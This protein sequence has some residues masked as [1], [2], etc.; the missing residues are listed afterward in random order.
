MK[1]LNNIDLSQNQLLNVR[2]QNL[3]SDPGSPVAGQVWFNTGGNVVKWYNGTVVIDPLARG[4]HTGTQAWTT[5][6]GT[7]T[8]IAGY[9]ILDGGTVTNVSITTANG[10]SGTVATSTTTPAITLTLGAITPTSVTASGTV[11][12]SNFTG[13]STGT[14][15]GDQTTITGNAGTATT[16]ATPRNINGVSFNGSADITVTAAAGTLTG[17]TLAAGVVNSSLT[18][19][20]TLSSL[21]VTG[22]ITAA[23]PTTNTQVATKQY[24]DTLINGL[25][26]KNPVLV[27]TTANITLSGTQ[28]IDGVA[29]V[30]GNR[31]LVKNQ[32]T[33]AENGIYVVDSGAWTRATDADSPAGLDSAAVL[34][35]TGTTQSDQSYTQN[36]TIVTVGTS[37]QSWVQFAA[38]GGAASAGTLTGTVL[39]SNVVTSSLTA[40][41]T[42]TNLT[43]TNPIAGS[44]TGNAAT[45]TTNAD[46]TGD[47]TSVGNATTLGAVGTAGTYRSVTTDSKGRVTA[48]TNPTTIAGYGITDAVGKYATD[49]GDGSA[50]SITVT[51]NLNTRDVTVSVRETGG[52]YNSVQTD[53]Q[54]ATV[55]TVTLIFAVAPTSAQY[56]CTVTG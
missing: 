4:N 34:V 16:L 2:L 42:L 12:G 56:R 50:T 21:S 14:N 6:T 31:V 13:S 1:F 37:D 29:V 48:G 22:N 38:A 11:T 9:G 15:T 41:G 44:V 35:Q 49:V 46:L 51:H 17:T 24:V 32:S 33:A 25:T 43:V 53:V 54:M 7:P 8:T 45:V 55:N 5:I 39:A 40:V 3:G 52:S 20:G 10:V 26:W 23:D 36:A 47:V 18:S 27:A 28:T 19:V 30:A